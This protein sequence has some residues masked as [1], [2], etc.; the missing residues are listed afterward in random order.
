ML[1][2]NVDWFQLCTQLWRVIKDNAVDIKE[3]ESLRK[4]MRSERSEPEMFDF[5]G[6]LDSINL[7]VLKRHSSKRQ[8]HQHSK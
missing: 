7:D 8:H 4:S 6:D 3:T 1:L 2:T 5:G